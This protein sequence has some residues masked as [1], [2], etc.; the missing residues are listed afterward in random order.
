TVI[1]VSYPISFYPVLPRGL[2]ES[3]ALKQYTVISAGYIGPTISH[4]K[5]KN[6]NVY[7]YLV[8]TGNCLLIE[9]DKDKFW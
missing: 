8:S 7:E 9:A 2:W 5:S 1:F 4:T 3:S 6:P